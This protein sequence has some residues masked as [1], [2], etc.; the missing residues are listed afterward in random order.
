MESFRKERNIL[1][2]ASIPV[3]ILSIFKTKANLI[4]YFS[5]AMVKTDKYVHY[6]ASPLTRT[7]PSTQTPRT[8]H[9]QKR[10]CPN[11]YVLPRPDLQPAHANDGL[12]I[13]DVVPNRPIKL[14]LANFFRGTSTIPKEMVVG[15]GARVLG[16]MFEVAPMPN[17][18][19][20]TPI[21][22]L[23]HNRPTLSSE[24]QMPSG[25]HCSKLQ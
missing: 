22:N 18:N 24:T 8:S 4:E 17:N 10:D 15:R 13:V 19:M 3:F 1:P 20:Y 6:H 12:G 9:L 5:R 7:L 23:V 21:V 11:V 2:D 14:F 16:R 25:S